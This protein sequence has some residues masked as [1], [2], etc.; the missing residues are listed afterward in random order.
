MGI[1]LEDLT[2]TEVYYYL[3]FTAFPSG[4][5]LNYTLLYKRKQI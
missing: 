3:S 2:T 1:G 4:A 5:F